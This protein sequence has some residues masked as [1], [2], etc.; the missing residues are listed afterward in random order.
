MPPQVL[1]NFNFDTDPDPALHLDA[2]PA[3]TLMRILIRLPKKRCVS[4]TLETP[5]FPLR[6]YRYVKFCYK[7]YRAAKINIF[8]FSFGVVFLDFNFSVVF[9]FVSLRNS[10]WTT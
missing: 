6:S 5:L 8:H 7:T 1:L 9:L 3:F 2:D 4:A 10:E